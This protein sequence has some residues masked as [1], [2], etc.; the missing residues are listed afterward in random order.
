MKLGRTKYMLIKEFIQV[1]R[2]PR[3]KAVIFIMPIVQTLVFGY[4]VTTDVKN[5]RLALYDLDG[6]I[7]SRELASQFS[8]T[9]YFTIIAH[10]RTDEEA[11]RLVDRAEAQA[12][13]RF[14]H[15]FESD[16]RSGRSATIQM[17]VD[18]TDSNTAGIILNY[19]SK[20]VG[21]FS[22]QALLTRMNRLAGGQ[23]GTIPLIIKSRA[24][25][26]ANLESRNFYVPGVIAILVMLIT[27]ML[28]SMAIVREKEVGTMEQIMVTP[29][30][31]GEFILGLSLIH[32]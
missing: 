29:I 1:F 6:S 7:A 10:V 2:D 9:E 16:L 19:A 24:W 27:L 15:G 22:S 30:T 11:Q 18:G 5:V 13:L 32:I 31:P 28:T 17:F 4:A 3:M 23:T 12:V 26:N 8:A 25:F 20:I 14:N 21:R